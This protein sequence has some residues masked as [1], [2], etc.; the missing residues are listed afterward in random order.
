MFALKAFSS[1]EPHTPPTKTIRVIR[2][3]TPCSAMLNPRTKVSCCRSALCHACYL[4]CRTR[5]GSDASNLATPACE[6]DDS[7]VL[8]SSPVP[9]LHFPENPDPA[10]E[11]V[12]RLIYTANAAF[13]RSKGVGL[14]IA[15]THRAD[16]ICFE[17]PSFLHSASAVRGD[18]FARGIIVFIAYIHYRFT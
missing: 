16:S 1:T 5:F 6:C 3:S 11:H 13:A 14:T 12:P 15:S 8:F 17:W 18:V 2:H 7:F 9:H 10:F 4:Y